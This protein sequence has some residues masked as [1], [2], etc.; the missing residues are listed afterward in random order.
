MFYQN[1]NSMGKKAL[2]VCM[3]LCGVGAS[4]H[5]QHIGSR[6]RPLRLQDATG[7][8]ELVAPR[9]HHYKLTIF[10]FL[11]AECPIVQK[12]AGVWRQLAADFPQVQYV[13]VFT[14]WNSKSDI[15]QFEAT[16]STGLHLLRDC[17]GR[18]QRR[19][20]PRVTPEVFLYDTQGRLAYRGAVDNWFFGLGRYRPAATDHY[21]RDAIEACLANKPPAIRHTEAIGCMVGK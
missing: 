20:Q 6:F 2:I 10:V 15:A 12:Y 1:R 9:S 16:Y 19:L 3:L 17:K 18:L 7:Q 21:L 14:R 11:D 5:G 8:L 4:L 13:G